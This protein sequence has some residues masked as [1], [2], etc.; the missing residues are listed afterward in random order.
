MHYLHSE[1]SLDQSVVVQVNLSG[2]A[3][4]VMLLDEENFERYRAGE[5]FEHQAGGHYVHSPV[6]LRAPE[7]GA[8]HLVVDLGGLPGEVQAA[9]AVRPAPEA[10]PAPPEGPATHGSEGPERPGDPHGPDAA[11]GPDGAAREGES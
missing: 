4:N 3:A 11:K 5:A 7:D 1:L 2:D 9:V 10:E 8:W 6:V